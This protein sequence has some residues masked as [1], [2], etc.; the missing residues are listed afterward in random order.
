MI[1]ADF[2]QAL[3]ILRKPH[4]L[5][6]FLMGTAYTLAYDSMVPCF[7]KFLIQSVVNKPTVFKVTVFGND[8]IKVNHQSTRLGLVCKEDPG[9]RH[10]PQNEKRNCVVFRIVRKSGEKMLYLFMMELQETQQVFIVVA[11]FQNFKNL[12]P[13]KNA[14]QIIDIDHYNKTV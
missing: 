6:V 10:V 1:H 8:I 2:K 9:H 13:G 11:Y 14:V 12:F 7:D 4:F 5:Q 3:L